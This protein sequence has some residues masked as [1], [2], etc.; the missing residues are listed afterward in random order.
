M[1]EVELLEFFSFRQQSTVDDVTA[2]QVVRFVQN[3]RQDESI[4]IFENKHL[5]SGFGPK[6]MDR[7]RAEGVQTVQDFMEMDVQTMRNCCVG[8]S[9]N[10][11][12]AVWLQLQK[13]YGRPIPE[14]RELLEDR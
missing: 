13:K 9:S 6:T 14:P 5:I 10:M 8:N 12:K 11:V 3:V 1:S 7:I 2:S 4:R